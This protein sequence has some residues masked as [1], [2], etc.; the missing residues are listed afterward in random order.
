MPASR[1]TKVLSVRL[2]EPEIRRLK[3]LAASR[4]I[5]VQEAVQQALE[6]W[7][8]HPGKTPT[9]PLDAL[10]GSLAD[11]DV[12]GLIRREKDAELARERRW[13]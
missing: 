10:Q 12:Q 9:E 8:V 1:Q 7:A 5:T 4:G 11:V 6:H 13:S 3:T 2:P